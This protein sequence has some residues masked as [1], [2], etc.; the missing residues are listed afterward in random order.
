MKYQVSPL[1]DHT[2]FQQPKKV[3]EKDR[4]QTIFKSSIKLSFVFQDGMNIRP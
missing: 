4:F 3:G 1:G 2:F